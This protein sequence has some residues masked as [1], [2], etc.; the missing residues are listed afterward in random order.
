MR[1]PAPTAILSTLRR[2]TRAEDGL[3]SILGAFV[4]VMMVFVGGLAIDVMRVETARTRLQYTLDRAV[5]AAAS[6]RDADERDARAVVDDYLRA[7]GLERFSANL[8]VD[9]DEIVGISRRVTASMH[10]PVPSLFVHLLGVDDMIAPARAEAAEAYSVIEIAMVLD[11][12][13][14]MKKNDLPGGETRIAALRRSATHFVDALFGVAGTHT[15]RRDRTIMT[16][17]PYS[18][19][20][21]IGPRNAGYFPF[22]LDHRDAFCAR[23]TPAQFTT[24]AIP[25]T[26]D[27]IRQIGMFQIHPFRD[28]DDDGTHDDDD[29]VF[30]H[31]YDPARHDPADPRTFGTINA[32]CPLYQPGP[33]FWSNDPDALRE[34]IAALDADG[35]TATDIATKWGVAALDPTSRTRLSDMITDGL[36]VDGRYGGRPGPYGADDTIKVLVLMTDGRIDPTE[37]LRDDR[38]RGPSGVFASR[39]AWATIPDWATMTPAQR[40]AAVAE[41]I[42]RDHHEIRFS[43]RDRT[44][45]GRFYWGGDT[46]AANRD[47]RTEAQGGPESIELTF[48]ELWNIKAQEYM[49]GH[50]DW[51]HVPGATRNFYGPDAYHRYHVNT[52]GGTAPKTQNNLR[53]ICTAAKDQGVRIF[54]VGFKLDS[55]GIADMEACASNLTTFY[56]V[57]DDDLQDAFDSIARVITQLKLTQ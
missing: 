32:R 22:D 29:D 9:V 42:A 35:G 7:A 41:D 37:D 25:Q 17:V 26:I 11:Q 54:T 20:V 16:L 49:R 34:R 38:R 27:S 46:D 2:F 21:N 39:E 18:G 3:A 31:R 56:D 40:R 19:N 12:S 53:A 52:V 43:V 1:I 8:D 23:F 48:Q 6:L 5:L 4:F 45:P 28:A 24:P 47:D 13:G 10:A 57:Q 30:D 51:A 50:D 33:V 44:N 15:D 36:P 14:S 55:A